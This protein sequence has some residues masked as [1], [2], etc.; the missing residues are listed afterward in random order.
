MSMM[1]GSGFMHDEARGRVAGINGILD[2]EAKKGEAS[3][4]LGPTWFIQNYPVRVRGLVD[5]GSAY[6]TDGGDVVK[7]LAF[8][9]GLAYAA[10]PLEKRKRWRFMNF[11]AAKSSALRF[12]YVPAM[13]GH[14][15]ATVQIMNSSGKPVSDVV[16]NLKDGGSFKVDVPAGGMVV[17]ELGR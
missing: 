16:Y 14:E 11:F 8:L 7:P 2:L 10:V 12:S 1:D 4:T 3:V 13:P 6:W 9:D 17:R 5:N 15:K